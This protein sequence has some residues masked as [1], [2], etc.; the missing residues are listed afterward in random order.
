MLANQHHKTIS[1]YSGTIMVAS[2]E[3]GPVGA[4][5]ILRDLHL[6]ALEEAPSRAARSNAQLPAPIRA[7]AQIDSGVLRRLLLNFGIE[8]VVFTTLGI[9][10]Q[11]KQVVSLSM[12]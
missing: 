11:S 9:P 5:Q 1:R 4:S 3:F 7:S 10:I 2:G 6:A 8:T 12:F